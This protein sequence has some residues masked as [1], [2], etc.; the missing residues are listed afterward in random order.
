MRGGPGV[1]P[2]DEA[3]ARG[4]E[5]GRRTPS[6]R[7]VSEKIDPKVMEALT[8]IAGGEPINDF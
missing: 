5:E 7:F 8:T 2:P 4:A 3:S 6:V 1:E